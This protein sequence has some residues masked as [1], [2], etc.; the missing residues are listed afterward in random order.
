MFQA[1]G[2]ALCGAIIRQLHM[3]GG[4]IFYLRA[5]TTWLQRGRNWIDKNFIRRQALHL[6]V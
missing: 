2:I 5:G 1:I 4:K 3:P 6:K